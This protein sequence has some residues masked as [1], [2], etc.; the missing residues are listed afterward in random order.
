M[1]LTTFAGETKLH[2]TNALILHYNID[3]CKWFLQVF[4]KK[5]HI[6]APS[7]GLFRNLHEILQDLTVVDWHF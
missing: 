6:Y 3:F 5:F 7:I 4:L 2:F 1:Y